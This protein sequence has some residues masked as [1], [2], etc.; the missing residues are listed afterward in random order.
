MK[1]WQGIDVKPP[2]M[3]LTPYIHSRAE[4]SAAA[5]LMLDFGDM[6]KIEANSRAS[7][8]RDRGNLIK[9]CHWRQVALLVDVMDVRPEGVRL[10]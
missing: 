7:A 9:F 5:Q 2:F 8:S 1:A 3:H 4:A 6:A 10:N